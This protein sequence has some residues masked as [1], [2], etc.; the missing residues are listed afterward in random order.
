M[1]VDL[2]DAEGGDGEVDWY[3][4]GEKAAE[5]QGYVLRASQVWHPGNMPGPTSVVQ[6]FDQ[7]EVDR[8]RQISRESIKSLREE[9]H[10]SGSPVQYTPAR[11]GAP[12]YLT[13]D[14]ER[15]QKGDTL[16]F[17]Q[18]E[19]I[20]EAMGA[21]EAWGSSRV[22]PQMGPAAPPLSS[23]EEFVAPPLASRKVFVAGALG[24]DR[25]FVAP[26][27]KAR[28]EFVAPELRDR[29]TIYED[30]GDDKV[31]YP[32]MP[33]RQGTLV[34]SLSTISLLTQPRPLRM[35][36]VDSVLSR[37]GRKDG[38]AAAAFGSAPPAILLPSTAEE[39]RR[40]LNHELGVDLMFQG[41]DF[42]RPADI[43]QFNRPKPPAL[44]P[45]REKLVRSMVSWAAAVADVHGLDDGSRFDIRAPGGF[46]LFSKSYRD[47]IDGVAS[48]LGQLQMSV[49]R[50]ISP[51]MLDL[52][53][54]FLD[55]VFPGATTFKSR[56]EHPFQ[57]WGRSAGNFLMGWILPGSMVEDVTG[58]HW[59]PTGGIRSSLYRTMNNFRKEFGAPQL[60]EFLADDGMM[61]AISVNPHPGPMGYTRG[62]FG[63]NPFGKDLDRW[64]SIRGQ[65]A[66]GVISDPVLGP[67][68]TLSS[69]QFWGG[70]L[71]D[72]YTGR[73]EEIEPLFRFSGIKADSTGKVTL[74]APHVS[75]QQL[76]H[77]VP[78]SYAWQHGA[79]EM[80]EEAYRLFDETAPLPGKGTFSGVLRDRLVLGASANGSGLDGLS[81][82]SYKALQIM[83]AISRIGYASNP[84]QYALVAAALNQAKGDKG[85]GAW[86]PFG[87]ARS[88]A[89]HEINK[90][91]V[92]AWRE[93]I[94]D[95]RRE[96]EKVVGRPLPDFLRPGRV[97]ELAMRRVELGFDDVGRFG[98]LFTNAYTRYFD[99]PDLTEASL[100]RSIRG[101]L[102]V[103]EY[104]FATKL[105]L[106]SMIPWS[107]IY[108]TGRDYVSRGLWANMF[109]KKNDPWKSLQFWSA[110]G[111]ATALSRSRDLGNWFRGRMAGIPL[112]GLSEP[113]LT[114]DQ[115]IFTLHDLVRSGR[116]E[117]MFHSGTGE[118]LSR[119]VGKTY[120][121]HPQ[122][123]L[124]YI[125]GREDAFGAPRTRG[126]RPYEAARI[127]GLSDEV[128][129]RYL[130]YLETGDASL[131]PRGEVDFQ[132]LTASQRAH[133]TGELSMLERAQD[134]VLSVGPQR[135]EVLVSLESKYVNQDLLRAIRRGV[136]AEHQVVV[137][138]QLG[139]QLLDA[140][141][142]Y[143][144]LLEAARARDV[145]GG[146]WTFS[147]EMAIKVADY[148]AM[149]LFGSGRG[150]AN[151][152][153][154]NLIP[155][156]VMEGMALN[157]ARFSGT[158]VA[159]NFTFGHKDFG[160]AKDIFGWVKQERARAERE[161]R[162]GRL[163]IGRVWR[164]FRS[165]PRP[166]VAPAGRA[167]DELIYLGDRLDPVA[168][169]A[170]REV[171]RQ[172]QMEW[173]RFRQARAALQARIT[174]AKQSIRAAQQR[175][176]EFE[177]I[178]AEELPWFSRVEEMPGLAGRLTRAAV[179]HPRT[180][181]AVTSVAALPRKVAEVVRA[182]YVFHDAVAARVAA[183]KY[184][185]PIS[186]VVGV[187]LQVLGIAE[188]FRRYREASSLAGRSYDSLSADE[189]AGLE[190]YTEPSTRTQLLNVFLDAG[191]PITPKMVRSKWGVLGIGMA[192]GNLIGQ[193]MAFGAAL[194]DTGFANRRLQRLVDDSA[195]V[196]EQARYRQQVLDRQKEG[197]IQRQNF[198][199]LFSQ[200]DTASYFEKIR[201]VGASLGHDST[202]VG[203]R[204]D[205]ARQSWRMI[206]PTDSSGYEFRTNRF[207]RVIEH[208]FQ[209]APQG[210]S[211]VSMTVTGAPGS[212]R[213]DSA[214]VV[215]APQRLSRFDRED[216]MHRA[217]EQVIRNR[218]LARINEVAR[219]GSWW[220]AALLEVQLIKEDWRR[221]KGFAQDS[222][223]VA[224]DLE[225]RRQLR[226][227]DTLSTRPR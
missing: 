3:L 160:E 61:R 4:R 29:M 49:G 51:Y 118:V 60:A 93:V 188:S 214:R 69:M 149:R 205:A 190:A 97:D 71:V 23:R 96:M 103:G 138:S 72:P 221:P 175:A 19:A 95:A 48:Q 196:Q 169:E 187:G 25:V 116:T 38:F 39:V 53:D 41:Y 156:M 91:Y 84:K 63:M 52:K 134:R 111:R 213:F 180:V 128:R 176:P 79:Q 170:R 31:K 67:K 109:P 194:Q 78:L 117:E 98:S 192:S 142:L 12:A 108:M 11:D 167:M 119:I 185:R 101:T 127:Q 58:A 195:T 7:A 88:K 220:R 147:K 153:P 209:Q 68:S 110:E 66:A 9:F 94:P 83:E 216:R 87:W 136:V 198:R 15:I 85:P 73:R 152:L 74:N 218:T 133:W 143:R 80:F 5:F 99:S 206:A 92:E 64:S 225:Q 199:S 182:P 125:Q 21:K 77:V 217:A 76:D 81:D 2:V 115:A 141:P 40:I 10:A 223:E 146:V 131:L 135:P 159:N 75:M 179:T 154:Q 222:L 181:A 155:I 126:L 151:L 26:T 13:V 22:P 130:Q 124:R 145:S 89:E 113:A 174:E 177:R 37:V 20:K 203:K 42:A 57:A 100:Y 129:A 208:P 178:L 120:L 157:A 17:S 171:V 212:A 224:R 184:L 162:E 202:K 139:R 45:A 70:S 28:E 14:G 211:D 1:P 197:V 27:L 200:V 30:D 150:L 59:L 86:L 46:D 114:G 106:W 168:L 158:T 191:A 35:E 24:S 65:Q 226:S 122:Q 56:E 8:L 50:V 219:E 183:G 215:Q 54:P 104:G 105:A 16:S 6:K 90:A 34:D 144:E 32:T 161:I 18:L 163:A 173:D 62:A 112:I 193:T 33:K 55:A 123:V 148:S 121:A 132:G 166:P 43:F 189:R 210:V 107:Q 102:A 36:D 44:D 165:I 172:A 82:N 204:V 186:N 164:E 140:A 137:E 207:G 227:R 47:P 201:Q